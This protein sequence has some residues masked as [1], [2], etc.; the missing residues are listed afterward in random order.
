MVQYHK[1]S[2]SKKSGSGGLLR[3]PFDKR[4]HHLGG[5]FSKPKLVKGE[6]AKEVRVSLS[7]KGGVSKTAAERVLYA[8]ISDNGKAQKSKIL[9]VLETPDNRHFARENV[10]TKGAIVETEMGRARVTSRP[11]QEGSV[12][13][14]LLPG[15]KKAEAP[16]AAKAAKAPKP[17]KKAEAPSEKAEKA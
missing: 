3:M 6:D 5:F 16:K 2:R 8:C 11:G 1:R 7:K 17:A 9:T 10:I 13:A 4:K 12:N 14:I 15:E